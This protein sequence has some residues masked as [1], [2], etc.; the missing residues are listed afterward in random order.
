MS[1]KILEKLNKDGQK[2]KVILIKIM[3][4]LLNIEDK[5]VILSSHG[6][7][8]DIIIFCFL[9]V[10]IITQSKIHYY[11]IVLKTSGFRNVLK[12]S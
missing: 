3:M 12:I 2:E 4:N 6:I 10:R 1:R 5:P 7:C 8:Y 11:R 9:S